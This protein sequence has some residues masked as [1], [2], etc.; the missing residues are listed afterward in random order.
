MKK[1]LSSIILLLAFGLNAFAGYGDKHLYYSWND[2]SRGIAIV[3]SDEP[4]NV[5][6]HYKNGRFFLDEACNVECIALG[7][8]GN[9][10]AAAIAWKPVIDSSTPVSDGGEIDKNRTAYHSPRDIGQLLTRLGEAADN[11]SYPVANLH[12]HICMHDNYLLDNTEFGSGYV[13]GQNVY[14]VNWSFGGTCTITRKSGLTGPLISVNSQHLDQNINFNPGH[15]IIDNNTTSNDDIAILVNHGALL[16]AAWAQIDNSQSN[17]SDDNQYYGIGVRLV[18]NDMNL[19]LPAIEVGYD[20]SSPYGTFK[21]R[22]CRTAID[23]R[24]G[25]FRFKKSEATN[26][27]S[28]GDNK[29]AVNMTYGTTMGKWA[30]DISSFFASDWLVTLE[31]ATN[32]RS[33]DILFTSGQSR[34]G[35]LHNTPLYKTDIQAMN[36]APGSD[37]NQ[38]YEIIF[39][40]TISNSKSY[41]SPMF[42]LAKRCIYNPRT[43]TWY[44][45]LYNALNDNSKPVQDGDVLVYY[46]DVREQHNVTINNNITIRSAKNQIGDN[47]P[48]LEGS[49]NEAGYTST[50]VNADGVAS[51]ITVAAGKT[52]TMG[53]DNSGPLTLDLA[54]N[55]R[56]FDVKG[57][58]NIRNNYTLTGGNRTD[59]GAGVYVQN[60]ATFNMTGGT[61]TDCAQAQQSA[62]YQNGTMNLE[63]TVN[64]GTTLPVY[65]PTGK[66]ITKTGAI[67]ATG[68]I[69]TTL[70]DEAYGRDILVSKQGA[71][72]SNSGMVN[73]G[74]DL[75]LINPV[76]TNSNKYMKQYN[77]TGNDNGSYSPKNVIELTYLVKD[78]T[79]VKNGL[80]SGDSAIFTVSESGSSTP[81]YTVSVSGASNSVTIKGLQAKSYTVTEVAGWSWAY[82]P[83]TVSKTQDIATNSTFT[84]SN[85]EKTGVA[86]HSENAKVNTITY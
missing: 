10:Y 76:L 38:R 54:S 35:E 32:W 55:G 74:S 60:G 34:A 77:A 9:P 4:N 65:L 48:D 47:L 28:L 14:V 51:F 85:T 41:L 23:L 2:G 86:D 82:T 80:K 69:S 84:F 68:T 24:A 3:N 62:V 13:S 53:G 29:V 25:V 27:V 59:G 67:S 15:V 58:L 56:G 79:I 20:A 64:F 42:L 18:N 66:V 11:L 57:T 16:M 50:W 63:G 71:S 1:I 61:I 17:P 21:V 12:L 44:S 33:G 7:R 39:D 36:F 83:G 45:T 81:L 72:D 40:E 75:T 19:H 73:D 70:Q 26:G 46:G 31:G 78:L 5:Y 52:L 8:D 43:T 30:D 37:L 6:L 22:H 49:I